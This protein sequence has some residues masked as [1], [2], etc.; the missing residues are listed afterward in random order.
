M[1]AV[2][3]FRLVGGSRQREEKL[4]LVVVAGSWVQ[5]QIRGKPPKKDKT[6]KRVV[7]RFFFS[8][9][10]SHKTPVLWHMEP[11]GMIYCA[12]KAF[13]GIYSNTGD[14]PCK[15]AVLASK[16]GGGRRGWGP[17]ARADNPLRTTRPAGQASHC[18]RGQRLMCQRVSVVTHSKTKCRSIYLK[19]IYICFTSQN[20]CKCEMFYPCTALHFNHVVFPCGYELQHLS[21]P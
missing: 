17:L 11:G 16:P 2:I 4:V 12:L 7:S 18:G 8:L 1:L 13:G 5:L 21:Q 6:K 10:L 3:M 15:A 14:F 19:H 20:R 9:T